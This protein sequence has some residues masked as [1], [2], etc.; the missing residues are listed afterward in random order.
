MFFF[1]CNLSFFLRFQIFFWLWMKK[2]MLLRIFRPVFLLHCVTDYGHPERPFFKN[3]ELL[4]LGRHCLRHLGVFSDGL[5]T[6]ILVLWVPCPCFPLFNHY[7]Y[8]KTKPLYLTTKYLF[9]SGIWIW[10]AKNLRFSLRVSVVRAMN[11]RPVITYKGFSRRN[12]K[13]LKKMTT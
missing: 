1:A 6:P 10:A 5:S 12:R 2:R 4:G 3:P 8:K 7:F 9:G 11:H 13:W